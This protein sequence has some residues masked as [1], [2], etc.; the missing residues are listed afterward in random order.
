[1]RD[2]DDF[3]TKQC[4]YAYFLGYNLVINWIMII[5]PLNLDRKSAWEKIK[6]T[7]QKALKVFL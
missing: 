7:N 1:M 3:E 6:N 2:V 5:E 4:R